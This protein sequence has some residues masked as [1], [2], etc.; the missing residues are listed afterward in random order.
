VTIIT[1]FVSLREYFG[2]DRPRVLTAAPGIL[3]HMLRSGLIFLVA[4]NA[5]AVSLPSCAQG[6]AASLPCELRFDLQSGDLPAS[7]SPFKD[8]LLNVEFRSPR[9]TTYLMRAFSDD[10]RS[11]RVRFT[12]PE[13]GSWTYHVSSSVKRYDNQEV[14]FNVADFAGPGLVNVAN[15]RHWRT[16]NKKPHLWLGVSLPSHLDQASLESW[17]DARKSDGFTHIRCTLLS[18]H[19]FTSA[20]EP[21]PAYF[22]ELDN[23]LLAAATR[24]FI[25]DL[26]LADESVVSSPAFGARERLDP[27]VRYLCS[28]YGALNVTWQGIE[29][30]EDVPGARALL[31][32]I[33][34]LLQKYDGFQHPR[35]TDARVSSSPLLADGWM[36][37]LIEASPHPGFAAV[38]HQFTTQ[39]EIHL[40]T[41]ADPEAFRHE[42]WTST[43]NGEYPSITADSLKN[44]AN[45][46]AIR[47]WAKV[48]ADTRHWELE[49]YFDVDG[50]RAVG[51]DEVEYLAYA[52]T[53]GIVEITLPKHKYNPLWIN[54]ITGE[55]V[56][57]KD[58]KGEVFSRPTPD[59][60]HDWVLQVPR[61]GRKENMLRYYYFESQDP[62]VQEVE[63]DPAKAPFEIVDPPGDQVNS[64]IPTPFKVKLTRNNRATRNMQ[65]I[66]WGEVV[67]GGEGARVL[68]LGS[69]GN[70]TI[71]PG[72]IKGPGANLNLRV[73]ALN[74]NGKAY[75]INKVYRLTP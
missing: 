17:L 36:N 61:E 75:E 40:I 51:L 47:T 69:N 53:P 15:L 54:T 18:G 63:S 49:P 22:K 57:L 70:F 26:V 38:E 3:K 7:A 12:P 43:T 62:P 33:G 32:D 48:L 4:L 64:R 20:L 60:A 46:K 24:G 58:Y 73:Q 19:P 35:S 23:W 8:E 27:I 16:T 56:P 6:A 50:A 25:L 37:F 1:L 2:S 72:L 66:W 13:P 74:A 9:A 14:P 42:L 5:S 44:E 10:G 39:P 68:G 67:A 11:L 59:T 45:A 29:C 34:S 52:Q 30:F 71:P 65:Y 31:K 55:E 21:D 28:R 41:T